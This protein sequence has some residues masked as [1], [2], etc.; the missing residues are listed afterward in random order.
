MKYYPPL[1]RNRPAWEA[2]VRTLENLGSQENDPAVV[3][4]TGYLLALDDVC[5]RQILQVKRLTA[6]AETR[7]RKS[8]VELAKAEPRAAH[9]ESRIITLEEELMEQADRH[10]KLL[11]GV[12]LVERAKRKEPHPENADPPILEGIPMTL[13]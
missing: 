7:W 4:M 10:S 3:A 6:R 2:R 9:A 8:P 11:R 13:R 1:D 12:Y 5:D